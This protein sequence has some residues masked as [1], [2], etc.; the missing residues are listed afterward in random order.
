[1][2]TTTAL[3]RYI[4]PLFL[5]TSVAFSL[6][7]CSDK[8]GKKTEV[9]IPLNEIPANIINV[10]QTVLPGIALSEAEKETKGNNT[11]YEMEGKLINGKKYE[12]K[13]AA[14]GTIIKI[15]LDD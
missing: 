14:D 7:A 9:D 6:G 12:L 3:T 15:E 4:T 10:V 5:I 13:I 2:K 8:E 1:M 11:V